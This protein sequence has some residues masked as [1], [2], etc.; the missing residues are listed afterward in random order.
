LYGLSR[1]DSDYDTFEVYGYSKFRGKQRVADGLDY[2]RQSYDRFMRYCER[3][4]PQYLEAM[5]SQRAE[6]DNWPWPRTTYRPGMTMVRETYRRTVKNFWLDGVENGNFKKR[7]HAA[8]LLLNLKD[9]EAQGWFNPT[10]TPEQVQKV[11]RI[12]RR[13]VD[14]D[15]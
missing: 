7:R 11:N 6:V 1:P 10:L 13:G 9:M 12:A 2:T 3:G 15:F 14:T 4:V 8:R 5:F